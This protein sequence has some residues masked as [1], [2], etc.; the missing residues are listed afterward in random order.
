MAQRVY[1][2]PHTVCFLGCEHCHNDSLMTGVRGARPIAEAIIANLPGPE[3][4]H[5]LAE[6]LVGGGEALMRGAGM[7]ALVTAFRARFPRG[8]QTA[9]AERRAAGHVILA[10]QTTGLPLADPRGVPL[11]K[12][13]DYWLGL[14][15]DYFHVASNDIF[16]EDRRPDYPWEALRKSLA[17]Y[18]GEHGVYF[19]IYGKPPYRLVPSG[20]VLDNLDALAGHGATLLTEAGYCA[21]AW[22]AAANFLSGAGQAHPDCSEVVI[23]PAGWVHPCCWYELAP[24]L[25][26]LTTTGFEAGMAGLAEHAVCRALDRGDIRAVA[27]LAGLADDAAQQIQGR[28]GECG[29]CRLASARLAR[30]AE[31]AWLKAP[32]LSSREIAFYDRHLGALLLSEWERGVSA[33]AR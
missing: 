26:D 28:V 31:F 8:P 3:S 10:L 15:V 5:R 20:R 32:P 23:D 12:Q 17:R 19:H 11:S 27:R 24:G 7:E 30:R 6:V 22:E 25:F 2:V 16:H 9:L 18:G 14:G 4:R 33:V 29:L 1:W 21:T 13:I